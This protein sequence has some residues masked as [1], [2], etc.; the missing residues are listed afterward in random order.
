MTVT[1]KQYDETI[2]DHFLKKIDFVKGYVTKDWTGKGASYPYVIKNKYGYWYQRPIQIPANNYGFPSEITIGGLILQLIEDHQ[3]DLKLLNPLPKYKSMEYTTIG[4][5]NF[6]INKDRNKLRLIPK[7]K[8]SNAYEIDLRNISPR[9]HSD[10]EDI[11]KDLENI[12]TLVSQI[13]LILTSIDSSEVSEDSESA[14]I[15]LAN[16]SLHIMSNMT[17]SQTIEFKKALSTAIEKLKNSPFKKVFSNSVILVGTEDQSD[18]PRGNAIARY[19]ELADQIFY[20]LKSDGSTYS[21]KEIYITLI[22]EYGH[23]FHA[24]FM[25]NGYNNPKIKKLYLE[26]QEGTKTCYLKNLP[27]IGDPLS[28]LREDWYSVRM[29]SNEYYLKKIVG[30]NYIYENERGRI[31][32][33][34]KKDILKRIT[35]PSEYGA[36][37]EREFFAEMFTL[38]TLGLVKP[39]QQVIAD[40]FMKIINT[41][42]I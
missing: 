33:V 30:D 20:F 38:I 29:A 7:N 22:H 15:K 2:K 42:A 17:L 35:C 10:Y 28:D 34:E 32:E 4:F 39:N 41:E 37:N 12:K 18:S 25:K 8:D 31:K 40:K 24:H 5:I 9:A 21:N 16:V 27:K 14:I 23:R 36:K 13:K 19:R 6:I 11:V 3:S 26:S 1:Q